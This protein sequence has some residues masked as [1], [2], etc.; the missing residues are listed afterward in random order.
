MSRV[1][2]FVLLS[3]LTSLS[4]QYQYLRLNHIRE[5]RIAAPLYDLD[6]NFHT[7]IRP[8][9]LWNIDS[10]GASSSAW[11]LPLQ[12]N[13]SGWFGRKLWNEHLVHIKENEVILSIDPIVN[14]QGGIDVS[15]SRE[16][17]YTNTR[18][19]NVEGQLGQHFS[20]QTSYLENQAV[21]PEYISHFVQR[22]EVVPGQGF[23]RDFGENGYDYGI[24]SGQVSYTPNSTFSFTLGQGRNFFGEGYR[25]MLLSDAAFNYPFFRIETSFWKIKY[26][27]LWGQL[28]DIRPGLRQNGAYARKYFSSHYLSLNI[29]PRW[30]VSVFEA[31]ILGDTA[32]HRGI[33]VAFFNPVIFYRPVEFAVGSGQGNALLGAASSYKLRD[34]MQVYGQFLLDEFNLKSLT[35]GQGSWV[36][37]FSWQLGAKYFNSFGV[38]GLFTRFEY[39]AS[40]PYTY[41]HRDV[42]TNYGHYGQPLAHPWGSNFHEGILQV[43]LQRGRWEA[44]TRFHIGAMGLDSDSLNWGADIFRS[45]NDNRQNLGNKVAQGESGSYQYLVGRVAYLVNPASGLKLECGMRL[46][47]LSTNNTTTP[48]SG[49]QSQYFFVGLRTEFFNRYYDF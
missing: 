47:N 37:K 24:A 25:S 36:N 9:D 3:S 6:Q 27:N 31:I 11:Q 33:D 17:L 15:G 44:E 5:L 14:F 21:F 32:Q 2:T 20:F 39:N 42:I 1:F 38:Q 35:N 49:G 4:A 7:G 26:V 28:Y 18:G 19:F 34:G 30:N 40:R 41:S 48:F 45:Y 46:R 29:T 12:K 10:N 8:L 22:Q 23:A 43:V 13:V 16:L